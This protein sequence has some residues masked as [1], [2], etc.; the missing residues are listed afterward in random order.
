MSFILIENVA[1]L[2]LDS[3]GR[4]IERGSI[5]VDGQTIAAVGE[6]DA[7]AR[8]KAERI[9]DGSRFLAAPGLVNAH[10]HT[11]GGLSAG[12]QDSSSHPAF[13]W[14]N[15]ADTSARTP[16]E[17]YV[18][19]MLNAAQMLLGGITTA[20]DHFPA[21]NFGPEDVAAVVE[22]YRDCG[23]RM[24]LGLRVFDDDF[25][26]I[27]P[28]DRPLPPDLAEDLKR[29]A[30]LP[31]KPLPETRALIEQSVERYHQPDQRLSVFPSPTNPVRCSDDLLVMC[32]DIAERYNLGIHTHL[33]ESKIQTTVAQR[34]YGCTMVQ[35]L[36]RLGLLSPRLSCAHTIWIEQEDIDR[37]AKHGVVVVH[38]PESN[39]KL[40]TG[41]APIAQMLA[42]GVTVALGTDGSVTNDNLVLHEATRLA[43]IIGRTSQRDRR[44]WVTARQALGMAT[45]GGAKAVQMAGRIGRIEPGYRADIV[46]YDLDT[47][48]WTPLNDPVQQMVFA[49]TGGS[50]D[51]V[52]VDGEVL[53]EDG[54]I[55]AFDASAIIAE[56]KPMLRTIR[57]RNR[58]LYAFAR[59]MSEIFP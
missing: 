8:Q 15:Q 22:A 59:R 12:T 2:T 24:V 11:P 33:L 42:S 16:R 13:M 19:A 27:F 30:P 55:T 18:S 47:P 4:F 56:A 6:V 39:L 25:A 34:R 31:P 38:N 41:V 53:V 52:F 28:S 51:T 40:G 46:L 10:M 48:A 45:E 1:I 7:K 9:I 20:I 29:L 14:L 17:I 57:E 3:A 36:E 5:L 32:R 50:V 35:H 44:Q 58:D 49:E 23:M 21:Q 37:L 43:A 54:V 26:D